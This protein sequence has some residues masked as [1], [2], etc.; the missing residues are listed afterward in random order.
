[1]SGRVLLLAYTCEP[2]AGSEAGNGW[3]WVRAWVAAGWSVTVLTRRESKLAIE[4]EK[5]ASGQWSQVE[6]RYIDDSIPAWVRLP[7]KFRPYAKYIRFQRRARRLIRRDGGYDLA[8]HATWGTATFGSALTVADCPL[9]LGPIGGAQVTDPGLRYWFGQEWVW[10]WLR[11]QVVRV[12]L[13]G[14]GP[15]K[16]TVRRASLVLATNE[17]TASLARTLGGKRVHMM[18]A[19]APAAGGPL[20]NRLPAGGLQ[21]LWVGRMLP[22]KGLNLAIEAFA[23]LSERLPPAV[24]TIVG[25]GPCR[26]ESEALAKRLRISDRIRFVGR[27]QPTEVSRFYAEADVHLFPSLRDS[28]GAQLL[29]A[30]AFGLPSVVLDQHGAR[31]L[32][33]GAA[34]RKVPVRPVADLPRRLADALEE[35]SDPDKWLAASHAG[36]AFARLQ[37]W[38]SKAL[39]VLDTL[40]PSGE[41]PA[42]G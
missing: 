19:D 22:R 26:A 13:R 21:V 17:A 40:K 24:L 9:I 23:V 12:L 28:F 11:N 1:M 3:G 38:E 5:L 16:S 4:R 33:P 2:G 32:L 25:D 10:E 18:L 27:V 6:F 37:S 8:H 35:L 14:P 30:A 15:M 41:P 7:R 20:R 36:T 29:E 31:D 39:V 42:Q 34:A